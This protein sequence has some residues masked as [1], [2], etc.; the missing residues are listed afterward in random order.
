MKRWAQPTEC[1]AKLVDRIRSHESIASK[2]IV[3]VAITV[4]RCTVHTTSSFP[5]CHSGVGG[6]YQRCEGYDSH[7]RILVG[8][9]R[10]MWWGIWWRGGAAT[11]L[12]GGQDEPDTGTHIYN[13]SAVITIWWI[14]GSEFAVWEKPCS[15]CVSQDMGNAYTGAVYLSFTHYGANDGTQV[16]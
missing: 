3:Y 5:E 13:I 6:R 2:L 11:V 4:A 1:I 9:D 7:H 10:R 8:T 12:Y 14:R 16:I 15:I